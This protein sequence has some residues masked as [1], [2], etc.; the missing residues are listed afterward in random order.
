MSL[1]CGVLAALGACVPQGQP[2]A[3]GFELDSEAINPLAVGS[4]TWL[5][6]VYEQCLLGWPCGTAPPD[7]VLD[8]RVEPV[9]SFTVTQQESRF[10]IAAIAEGSGTFYVNV[11]SEGEQRELTQT[12]IAKR[13]DRVTVQTSC[14]SPALMQPGISTGFEYQVWHGTERLHGRIMPLTV[15]GADLTPPDEM[16]VPWLRLPT[17]PG[18][19][20][21]TSPYDS[22]FLHKIDVVD[23]N[24]IDSIAITGTSPVAV[25]SSN[26]FSAELRVGARAIC[27]G[28]MPITSTILTPS[29]CALDP[30]YGMFSDTIRVNGIAAGDCT[31]Q[32]TL[33]GT[34]LSATRTFTI[35]A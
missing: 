33:T 15:E 31:L 30:G 9:A 2:D 14:A 24:A 32:V 1:W 34:S 20:T 6:V 10:N 13:I 16:G 25:G 27:G 4:T 19:V 22:T 5:S 26:D 17:T 29:T 8:H 11:I 21:V 18:S 23:R 35:G 12:L 7:D 3:P 28:S